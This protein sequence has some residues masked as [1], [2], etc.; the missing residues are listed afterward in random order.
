MTM[1][2]FGAFAADEIIT[3]G[4]GTC[5]V[6]VLGVFD[7]NAT[8]NAIATWTLNEYT[9][10]PGQYL[11]VTETSVDKTTCPSGSY[12]IGGTGFTVDNAKN[13][14]AQC[15]TG[16]PNSANGASADTQCYTAC[17]VATANIAHATAVSGNDYYGTGVDT[18]SATACETGWHVE[19]GLNLL[20]EIGD[21]TGNSF[22]SINKVGS[23]YEYIEKGSKGQEYYGVTEPMSFAIDYIGK[24][25]LTGR[26]RCSTQPGDNNWANPTIVNN[27]DDETGMEG[28]QYC[29]CQVDGFVPTGGDKVIGISAPWVYSNGYHDSADYC[30]S[31][32]TI[33]CAGSIL[34]DSG[35]NPLLRPVVLKSIPVSPAT[36]AANTINIYWNPDNGGG[37]AKTQCRY[38]GA[39]DVPAD[40]V[41]PGY[42]FMGWKLTDASSNEGIEINECVPISLKA[43]TE[44]S[45][46]ELEGVLYQDTIYYK[47]STLFEDSDCKSVLNILDHIGDGDPFYYIYTIPTNDLYGTMCIDDVGHYFA[48]SANCRPSGP[49]TWYVVFTK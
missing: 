47:D 49:T 48:D 31:H 14:I 5:T 45:N 36:C 2:S 10:N 34:P 22:G 26:G 8:A 3:G 28:A 21:L 18:C 38:E 30:A 19:S 35:F 25:L 15:P 9:L 17:T 4:A 20:E 29:Y 40:P 41:K 24:G 37:I 7:N 39:I 23:F 11:S 43:I 32:C 33:Y 27:L 16:Y 42:T 12:C 6:D 46:R 44:A 1:V 13:S